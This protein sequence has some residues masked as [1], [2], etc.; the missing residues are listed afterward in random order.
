M[1]TNFGIFKEVISQQSLEQMTNIRK[2]MDK[3]LIV[4]RKGL[5]LASLSKLLNMKKEALVSP[6]DAGW[7]SY[8]VEEEKFNLDVLWK[9]ICASSEDKMD[10]DLR[11]FVVDAL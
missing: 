10:P 3:V 7:L 2:E 11:Q 9:G 5:I 4:R 1:L 8:A 6:S